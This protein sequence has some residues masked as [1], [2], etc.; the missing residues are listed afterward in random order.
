MAKRRALIPLDELRRWARV[1]KEEG[2]SIHGHLAGDGTVTIKL[3]PA[4]PA[5]DPPPDDLDERIA[6]FTRG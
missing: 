6:R 5:I 2:V 4:L 1:S 3:H